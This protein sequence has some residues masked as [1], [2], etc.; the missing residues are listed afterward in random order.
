MLTGG[1]VVLAGLAGC[2]DLLGDGPITFEASQAAI[3]SSVRDETGYDEQGVEE[4]LLERTVEVGDQ[5]RDVEV[6]NWQAEYDKA[7][8]LPIGERLRGSVCTVLA[9]PQAEVLGRAFN[10]IAEMDPAELLDEFQGRIEGIDAV[11]RVGE[12]A[13][14]L[15][16]T[17]AD[18]GRF[19]AEGEVGD[20]GVAVDIELLVTEPVE[21]G[22]D[23][24][25]VIAAF[26]LALAEQERPDA[27]AMIEGVDH[28]S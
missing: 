23:L 10:P 4:V 15:L 8:E 22:D 12:T 7:I 13:V 26:P 19:E 17:T 24:I 3:P 21:S 5:S 9:T 27:V 20:A 25:I 2:T 14:S 16:G 18:V 6:T 11:E 1:G 28:P